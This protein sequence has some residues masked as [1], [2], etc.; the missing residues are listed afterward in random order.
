M[1]TCWSL[2]CAAVFLVPPIASSQELSPGEA[3]SRKASDPLGNV[4]APTTDH[5][6]GFQAGDDEGHTSIGF[7]LRP[8]YAVPNTS[9][10]TGKFR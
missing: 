9:R 6:L 8:V 10:W 5:T 4:K 2:M 3:V 7:Q 1:K